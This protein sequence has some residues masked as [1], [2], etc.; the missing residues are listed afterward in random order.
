[1]L[2]KTKMLGLAEVC[3]IGNPIVRAQAA[4]NFKRPSNFRFAILTDSAP[5]R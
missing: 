3:L 4:G 2:V 5:F 1:M